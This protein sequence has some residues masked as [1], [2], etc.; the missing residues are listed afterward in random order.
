LAPLR[1]GAPAAFE[2]LTRRYGELL[3]LA[4]EQRGYKV[5]HRLPETLRAL[6]DELGRVRAGP[7]DVIELHTAALRTRTARGPSRKAQ[8]YTEEAHVMVLELMGYLAGHYRRHALLGA[9]S[10]PARRSP[11]PEPEARHREPASRG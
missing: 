8:A 1:V 4:L 2:T 3:D 6:A 11:A 9:A 7:R 10:L 5:D